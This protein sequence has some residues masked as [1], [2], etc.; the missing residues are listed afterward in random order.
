MELCLFT[1]G[2]LTYMSPSEH[3]RLSIINNT[4]HLLFVIYPCSQSTCCI[5]L[6]PVNYEKYT[7]QNSRPFN[8]TAL[9]HCL[10]QSSSDSLLFEIYL[11]SFSFVNL[12]IVEMPITFFVVKMTRTK[13]FPQTKN[14]P[15]PINQDDYWY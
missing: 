5:R 11:Q 12:P 13:I 1:Q 4:K 9:A 7:I 3:G 14:K 6:L 2:Q 10:Q 8:Y 15:R